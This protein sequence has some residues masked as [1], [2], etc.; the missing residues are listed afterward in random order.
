[1]KDPVALTGS[2]AEA[3][4]DKAVHGLDDKAPDELDSLQPLAGAAS[5][6]THKVKITK[7]QE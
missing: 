6:I 1:M 2:D 4:G 7:T 5:A 3:Y